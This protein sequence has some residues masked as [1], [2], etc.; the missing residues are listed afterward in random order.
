MRVTA[1]FFFGKVR[2]QEN[3]FTG[4]SFPVLEALNETFWP[5]DQSS[6]SLAQFTAEIETFLAHVRRHSGA[7]LPRTPTPPAPPLIQ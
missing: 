1:P 3:A 7:I 4:V 6:A 5:G 2:R